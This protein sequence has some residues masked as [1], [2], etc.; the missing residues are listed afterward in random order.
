M[1]GAMS[2]APDQTL[3]EPNDAEGADDPVINNDLPGDLEDE[4]KLPPGQDPN[5]VRGKSEQARANAPGQQK[6]Q[7]DSQ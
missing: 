4:N 1:M 2:D 3:P 7:P 6:K 5:K